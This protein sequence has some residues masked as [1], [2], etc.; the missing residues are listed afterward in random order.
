M[1]AMRLFAIFVTSLLLA[2]CQSFSYR[3]SVV[4]EKP[5]SNAAFVLSKWQIDGSGYNPVFEKNIRNF[6]EHSFRREGIALLSGTNTLEAPGESSPAVLLSV[7]LLVAKPDLIYGG[8]L[9]D[10]S[11]FIEGNRIDGSTARLLFTFT[12]LFKQAY[13][14]ADSRLMGLFREAVAEFKER[15]FTLPLS[16]KN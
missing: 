16:K 12:W 3:N 6:I 7:S 13:N 8:S 1:N 14:S 2:S 4:Y 11:L 15:L 9:A 5:Q 10:Y